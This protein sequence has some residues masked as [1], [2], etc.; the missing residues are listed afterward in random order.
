MDN[1]FEVFSK[2]LNSFIDNII[3]KSPDYIVPVKKKGCKLLRYSNINQSVFETKV[4]YLDYFK[5]S[6]VEIKGKRI[7]VV[8]DAAKYTSTLKKYRDF[9]EDEGAVVDTY[10]FVGHNKLL[11]GE[12]DQ[13]DVYAKVHQHLEESAYQEYIVQQSFVLSEADSFFDIDHFAAKTKMSP[14]GFEK[15]LN[16][17]YRIGDIDFT[18]DVYTPDFVKKLCVY[19]IGFFGADN[20]FPECISQGLL[21]K[22]RLAYNSDCEELTIIPL[23]FPKWNSNTNA[24]YDDIFKNITIE[25]PYK[26]CH[27]LTNDGIYFNIV[28]CYQLCLLKHFLRTFSDFKE[29][30]DIEFVKQDMIAFVGVEHAYNLFDSAQTYIHVFDGTIDNRL[31]VQKDIIEIPRK[32]TEEF[33]SVISIMEELR[34]KYNELVNDVHSLLGVRYFLSFEEIFE[35]YTGR[36][37]LLKWI[38]ILC[39]RGAL[40]TRNYSEYG[41]YYRACRSGEMNFDHITKR[42]E[43]LISIA[44]NSSAT[45]GSEIKGHEFK[46]VNATLLNKILANFAFDYPASKYDVHSLY[47]KPHYFGPLVYADTA[48]KEGHG[49]SLYRI[50]SDL[51]T[52]SEEKKAFVSMSIRDADFKRII[53]D[54]I[55]K[56]DA[57]PYVEIASYF[58]F[59]NFI[60]SNVS[61][62]SFLNALVICRNEDIYYKHVRYNLIR[63]YQNICEA[64]ECKDSIIAERLLR[65]AAVNLHSA[66]EKLSYKQSVVLETINKMDLKL[67][68]DYAREKIL[69]SFI[70]FSGKFEHDTLPL[71][72][73][74]C[75][76]ERLLVNLLLFKATNSDKYFKHFKKDALSGVYSELRFIV[77]NID[78]IE[79][80]INKLTEEPTSINLFNDFLSS[81]E[82]VITDTVKSIEEMIKTLPPVDKQYMSEKR[83]SNSIFAMNHLNRLVRENNYEKLYVLYYS[84]EGFKNITNAKDINVIDIV[85]RFANIYAE[86]GKLVFGANGDE[87]YGM[88]ATDSIT[89]AIEFSQKLTKLASSLGHVEIWFSC[90]ARKITDNIEECV[91]LA[92]KESMANIS[93]PRTQSG[94]VV[95]RSCMDL[96]REYNCDD[97]VR[98]FQRVNDDESTYQYIDNDVVTTSVI[99][100]TEAAKIVDIGIITVLYDEYISVRT[101]LKNCKECRADNNSGNMP[102]LVVGDIVAQNGTCHKIALAKTLNDGNNMAT[103]CATQMISA[104]PDVQV[105]FMVGIAGGTPVLEEVFPDYKKKE[106]LEQHVRLGD[107]VVGNSLVQYDYVKEKVDGNLLKGETRP[108]YAAALL[109]KQNLDLLEAMGTEPSQLPWNVYTSEALDKLKSEYR[110]PS[111]DTDI[112][113]DYNKNQV[114]HPFDPD[115]KAGYPKIFCGKIASGNRVL[116]NPR[117]RDELKKEYNVLAVEMETAGVADACWLKSKQYFAVRGIVDYCDGDKNDIWHKYSALVAAAYTRALIENL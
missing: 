47:T 81:V 4:R 15:L 35:R 60:R 21:Q 13:Y 49:E 70:D 53:N 66:N 104:F 34:Q 28:Y 23:S 106:I 39:D 46:S 79:N 61:S 68:F 11:T 2:S 42:T 83:H 7:A 55:G 74:L 73:K 33:P 87:P 3:E 95:S 5:N 38:D 14:E 91:E 32:G 52:Y 57:V 25:L 94:F 109:A 26:K 9:F 27:S 8:D 117:K 44:I 36:E 112:L 100:L 63:G 6:D 41:V 101:V 92:M 56:Q 75:F 69:N 96:I 1:T 62:D 16:S 65:D 50:K 90:G 116:K 12:R 85:Q 77:Q 59:M 108:P 40:V 67:E 29:L 97:L 78:K 22:V 105:I 24:D 80:C 82:E 31:I 71:L 86:H 111:P 20:L 93:Y 45:E 98:R 107:I 115:R 54:R 48:I 88:Y 51:F 110:R 84:Y 18:N 43:A 89:N 113:R 30:S 102:G 103:A 17:L 37:N 99:S 10:S 19:N 64:L 58:G 76:Y 114:E 72:R